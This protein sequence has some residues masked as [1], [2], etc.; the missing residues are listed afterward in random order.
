M[1]FSQIDSIS[2]DKIKNMNLLDN[3][4]K[5]D[6]NFVKQKQGKKMLVDMLI[7]S[8]KLIYVKFQ[9]IR[10]SYFDII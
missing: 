7:C 8:H 2:S 9:T 10:N 4:K 3:I 1:P 5:R 6:E